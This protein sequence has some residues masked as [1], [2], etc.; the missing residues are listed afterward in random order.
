MT[1]SAAGDRALPRRACIR[2]RND[3]R[4][5]ARAPQAPDG[6][7]IVKSQIH[8]WRTRVVRQAGIACIQHNV[9]PWGSACHGHCRGRREGKEGTEYQQY[10]IGPDR[11]RQTFCRLPGAVGRAVCGPA[12]W[13]KN[14]INSNRAA[15]AWEPP[16]LTVTQDRRR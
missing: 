13:R 9:A 11:G 6:R 8:A 16:S 15:L 7:A 1:T 12:T 3:N 14:D 5:R 4:A 10:L 2:R